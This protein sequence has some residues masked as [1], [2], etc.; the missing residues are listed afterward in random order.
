[1]VFIWLSSGVHMV[2]LLFSYCFYMVFIVFYVFFLIYAIPSWLLIMLGSMYQKPISVWVGLGIL[3]Y[4]IAYFLIQIIPLQAG[5][6]L[7]FG[8][9]LLYIDRFPKKSLF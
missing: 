4:G 6:L 7:P 9:E 1:M 8:T 5:Q 3:V 2:F